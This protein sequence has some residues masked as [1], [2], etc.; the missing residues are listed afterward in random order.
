M[1]SKPTFS[2]YDGKIRFNGE[3]EL[4]ATDCYFLFDMFDLDAKFTLPYAGTFEAKTMSFSVNVGDYVNATWQIGGGSTFENLK[5]YGGN[6]PLDKLTSFPAH[7][8]NEIMGMFFEPG[9]RA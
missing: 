1:I 5:G 8:T 9:F 6:H 3:I 7:I 4:N 2:E